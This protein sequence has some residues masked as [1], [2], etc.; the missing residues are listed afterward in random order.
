MSISPCRFGV[1]LGL[2]WGMALAVLALIAHATVYYGHPF[3]QTLDSVY[4]GYS[5]TYEGAFLGFVWGFSDF[6]LFGI[7]VAWIYNLLHSKQD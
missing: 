7:F 5:P 4:M 2:V 1:A 6:F 3:I